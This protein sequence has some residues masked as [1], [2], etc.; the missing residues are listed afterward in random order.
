[1]DADR[2]APAAV[3]VSGAYRRRMLLTVAVTGG[4]LVLQVIGGL[5]S[6]S[7][8]LLADS[9]HMLTDLSGVA[10]ALLA[11]QVA[12]RSPTL[13][14]TFG[15]YRLEILAAL[16]NAALLI[17]VFAWVASRAVQRFGQPVEV[18]G[19]LMLTVALIG[20]AANLVGVALLHGGKD[21][22]LN[23]RGAYLEV[24]GDALGS[25]AAIAAAVVIQLTGWQYA[26]PI[27]SLL[28]G[29]MI[30][31][32]AYLLGRDALRVLLEA[33]PEDVDLAELRS[34]LLAEDGVH[35][36]HDLHAWTITSGMPV[37]TAHVVAD[38]GPGDLLAR[39][40]GCVADHFGI[41]HATLQLEPAA[42]PGPES[43]GP[44]SPGR[45]RCVQPV[46]A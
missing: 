46:H 28:I 11:V 45:V 31:P 6:G 4:V 18:Q 10:L 35:E 20:L 8:A 12:Q 15:H 37:L 25:V 29:A 43:P 9:G 1:M 33:T 14:R 38:G 24:L 32:R 44:E 36:V 13:R 2:T 23:L 22:S 5:L 40:R 21:R 39:L 16:V 30:L 3:T 34:H 26:D 27:A 17:G 41:A 19:G 7:L 42:V